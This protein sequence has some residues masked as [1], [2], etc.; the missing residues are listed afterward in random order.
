MDVTARYTGGRTDGQFITVARRGSTWVVE[1][2]DPAYLSDIL[3]RLTG[4]ESTNTSQDAL[5]SAHAQKL[6]EIGLKLPTFEGYDARITTI[7]NQLPTL[8]SSLTTLS[9]NLETHKSD[10]TNEFTVVKQSIEDNKEK[11]SAINLRL[12][13]AE[14]KLDT[15]ATINS[16]LDT[17]TTQGTTFNKNFNDLSTQVNFLDS[18]R[19]TH[20][21]KLQEHTDKLNADRTDIDG[22][23]PLKEEV[24]TAK[25]RAEIYFN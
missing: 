19:L 17:L 3:T 13:T 15:L 24:K 11:T 7:A 8:Q 18:A 1:Q 16:R 23:L 14:N 25:E 21:K 4:V 9:T 20:D 6:N 22:L 2:N 12:N 10:T 5:L